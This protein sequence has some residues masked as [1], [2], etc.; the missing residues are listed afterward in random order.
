MNQP[1]SQLYAWR[2]FGF[3]AMVVLSSQLLSGATLTP[4]T[5]CTMDGSPAPCSTTSSDFVS[6][7]F[8]FSGFGGNFLQ[9]SLRAEART[10]ASGSPATAS[11]EAELIF[12][13]YTTGPV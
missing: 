3:L 6:T 8:I 1:I 12:D 11:A 10:G 4:V 9:L 2:V 7:P 5:S 13:A